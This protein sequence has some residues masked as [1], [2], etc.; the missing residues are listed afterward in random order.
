M[1]PTRLR[2]GSSLIALENEAQAREREVIVDVLVMGTKAGTAMDIEKLQAHV[3]A[4]G[5]VRA[6]VQALVA[7]S[8][9]R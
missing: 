3:L 4:R 8:P 9:S 6:V 7:A 5:N 1:L 2:H